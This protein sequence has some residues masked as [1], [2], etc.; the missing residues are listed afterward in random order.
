[1]GRS[2]ISKSKD[3]IDYY[4]FAT[5]G[6]QKEINRILLNSNKLSE[7]QLRRIDKLSLKYR[8]MKYRLDEQLKC[9]MS[10]VIRTPLL[11]EKENNLKAI[12]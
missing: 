6:E 5:K 2:L 11:N 12:K 7:A 4:N 9:R 8:R 3:I 10:K 1:M